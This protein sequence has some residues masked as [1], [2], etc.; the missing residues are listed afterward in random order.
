MCIISTGLYFR[1]TALPS[2]CLSTD[3]SGGRQ[4]SRIHF[5]VNPV[6]FPYHY[7]LPPGCTGWHTVKTRAFVS[8]INIFSATFNFAAVVDLHCCTFFYVHAYILT[9]TYFVWKLLLSI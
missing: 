4:W 2:V 3:F 9:K 1:V 8:L 5:S 7:P 6:S